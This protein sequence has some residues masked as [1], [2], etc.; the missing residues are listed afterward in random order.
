MRQC[1]NCDAPIGNLE[2][3]FVWESHLVCFG[4]YNR[5]NGATP[6]I[7]TKP[8]YSPPPRPPQPANNLEAL[9][10]TAAA[11]PPISVA[12]KP[13]PQDESNL[14]KT[15][16]QIIVVFGMFWFGFYFGGWWSDRRHL[17]N[18]EKIIDSQEAQDT[19]KAEV[20]GFN[21]G[22]DPFHVNPPPNH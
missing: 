21:K 11:S 7:S 19:Q 14:L 5:L 2:R 12:Q 17:V 1:K 13:Y 3:A 10:V 18:D 4:C 16:V 20:D 9:A 8:I 22:F 15:F 6:S